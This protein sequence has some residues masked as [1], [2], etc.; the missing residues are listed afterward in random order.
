MDEDDFF[1][2][3]EPED[4]QQLDTVAALSTQNAA[5]SQR[6]RE[7]QIGYLPD[8]PEVYDFEDADVIN[9]DEAPL[10]AHFQRSGTQRLQP[11]GNLVD[12]GVLVASRLPQGRSAVQLQRSYEAARDALGRSAAK[13]AASQS[14]ANGH[15]DTRGAVPT[16]EAHLLQRIEQVRWH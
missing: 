11:A 15:R 2:G 1:D 12:G 3:L 4:L 10:P 7:G 16:D 8:D 14:T 9:L 6:K 5:A 13:P